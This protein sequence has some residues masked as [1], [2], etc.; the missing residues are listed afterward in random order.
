MRKIICDV[1]VIG[2][3]VAGVSA[4]IGASEANAKT[5]LIERNPYFGGQATHSQVTAF[6][7]FYTRGQKPDLVIGGVGKRILDKLNDNGIPTQAVPSKSTGNSN[8][9]FDPEIMKRILDEVLQ[10]SEVDYYLHTSLVEV[11][12]DEDRI[13][14]II[15]SDDEGLF[16]IE[17][18]AFV[19]ASGN[20]NLVHLAGLPTIWGD[21]EGIV[22]QA[23]LSFR[24]NGLPR[25]EVLN[26]ELEVAIAK[27]KE[28]GIPDLHKEKGMIIKQP[29]EDFGYCTI[30][31]VTLRSLSG[32]EKTLAEVS[33]RQQVSAYTATF[34]KF[35]PDFENIKVITSG[36]EMGI[37]EAR[38]IIGE[39]QL[40]GEDILSGKKTDSS[41]GRA[42]WS[43]EI[44]KS[45]TSLK[46]IHIPDNEYASIPLGTLK[47][48]DC[49]NLWAAGRII[50]SDP[51][52]FASVRV[53]G[54]GFAIGQAAGVAAALSAYGKATVKQIQQVL[55]EQGAKI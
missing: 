35:I 36:P 5:V 14:H 24:V 8:V 11:V 13:S 25:R 3:G 32:K 26:S 51:L 15:C 48:K 47:V 38:R 6:C 19:D 45:D 41:I 30:P 31:S 53:M 9:V 33:L 22:Q 23:S 54:T 43:P 50:S 55:T 21:D 52:A 16:E 49:E 46:Y 20:A 12:L 37:R 42:A 1:A 34:K 10:E 18:K 27:G 29:N 28:S 2:G 39:Y 17:A 4:A 7:G 44:H 40:K